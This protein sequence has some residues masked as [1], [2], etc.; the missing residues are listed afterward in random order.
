MSRFGPTKPAAN[1]Q[2]VNFD[3][4]K[5]ILHS[6]NNQEVNLSQYSVPSPQRM[7]EKTNSDISYISRNNL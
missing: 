2:I 5:T 7:L 4:A 3:D 6:Q 1:K